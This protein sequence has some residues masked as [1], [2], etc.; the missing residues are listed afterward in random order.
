MSI[1]LRALHGLS[2]RDCQQ[3]VVTPDE[4]FGWKIIERQDG[5]KAPHS[6]CPMSAGCDD[7]STKSLSGITRLENTPVIYITTDT[8]VTYNGQCCFGHISVPEN[9]WANGKRFHIRLYK[10]MAADRLAEL[11]KFSFRAERHRQIVGP[12]NG[13]VKWKIF[14]NKITPGNGKVPENLRP[15]VQSFTSSLV[16]YLNSKFAKSALD[17]PRF[18]LWL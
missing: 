16:Q 17:A 12:D 13:Q 10:R 4:I 18:M 11:P 9:E 6:F 15:C 5:T 8:L 7:M 1:S 3:H 14:Q 2:W